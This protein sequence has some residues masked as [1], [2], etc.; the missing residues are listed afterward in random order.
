M[1]NEFAENMYLKE[2]KIAYQS[3]GK[4]GASAPTHT[5]THTHTHAK[6]ITLGSVPHEELSPSQ[7][8]HWSVTAEP[9]GVPALFEKYICRKYVLERRKLHTNQLEKEMQVHLPTHNHTH[10]HTY[11]RN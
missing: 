8:P 9:F 11:T 6:K 2:R 3:A 10:T 4:R 1:K 7:T 5:H